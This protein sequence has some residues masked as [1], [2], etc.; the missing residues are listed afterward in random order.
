MK[1]FFIITIII[2]LIPF[3]A[4]AEESND[5]DT[6]LKS[7]DL[8][9]FEDELDK[10]TYSYLEQLGLS[11][12]NFE[13][14]S[15]L[16]INDVLKLVSSIISGKFETPFRSSITVLGFIILS[17]LLQGLK[18]TDNSSLNNVYSTATS[19][20]VAVLLVIK[21]SNTITLSVSSLKIASSFIYAF[22]PTLCALT[23]A[24]GGVSTMFSTNSMLLILSQGISFISGSVFIPIINCFLSLGICSGLKN[25]I[26]LN[27]L[28]S[29]LKREIT[30]AI[31]VISASFV[32]ILS[33]KTA[34]A[35]RADILG[36]RS[37]RLLI[38]TVVPVIGSSISE[39][40]LSI[41]GYSSLIKSS[42]GIVGIIAISLVFI[43]AI[44]EVMLWRL[45]LSVSQIVAN[46]FDDGSCSRILSAFKDT[47]LIINIILILSMVTTIISFGILIAAKTA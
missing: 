12:F 36:I 11:D 1:R 18:S 43:P 28:L 37:V 29:S 38:N 14:I 16:S 7:Y 30:T 44:I 41:Q 2:L 46:I 31:S 22:I 10:E 25:E 9:F 13:S 17:S 39:G 21:I 24:S 6:Y 5:Y 33:I 27:L 3:V 8:S 32:S 19:L 45:M 26:N 40:L 47:M 42:V 20:V 23:I 34:I 35:S 15:S 4:L